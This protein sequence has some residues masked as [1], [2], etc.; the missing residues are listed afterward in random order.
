ME[1]TAKETL[2]E[3]LRLPF[4]FVA[5]V[6]AVGTLGYLWL[7]R[8]EGATLLDALYMVFLTMTTIGYH[9]V[10]PVDTAVERLFTMFV[11]TAGI[12]SLFYAFGVFMDFLVEEGAETRRLRAMERRIARLREH[13]VL[14]GYGRVGRQAAEA[15]RENQTPFVV[16]EKDPSRVRRAL[17]EGV[18]VLEGDAGED[19]VLK[20]AG[21]DRARG[22]IAATGSDAENLFIVITA[23]GLAPGLFIVSR[24][25]DS[26]V[27][28]KMIRAGANKVI[29]PYAVGGQRLANLVVHPVVVDFLETTLRRGGAPLSIEDILVQ[30]GSPMAGRSLAELDIRRKYDV[31]VLAVI[32]GGEPVVNPPGDFVLAPGDQL[33]VLGTREAL[34]SLEELAQRKDDDA[35][36]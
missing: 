9:E 13:V 21:V 1:R 26:S 6:A 2:R 27:V 12:M 10:Y 16:V 17:A 5:A 7:W 32:R 8:D 31:T 34:S 14:V 19:V 36:S 18:L 35:G 28:P 20:K 11:G 29:D 4:L 25:E 33:I 22:L 3:R 23:R 15:L 24:A 30:P